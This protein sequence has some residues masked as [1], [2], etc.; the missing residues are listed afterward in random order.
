[1]KDNTYRLAKGS[2]KKFTTLVAHVLE[3][4]KPIQKEIEESKF[5]INDVMGRLMKYTPKDVEILLAGSVARGTQIRGN[6]DIDIFLLFPRKMK[7]SCNR[8]EGA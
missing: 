6:S 2:E 4:V 7:E 1:M 5:T 3:S 8:E